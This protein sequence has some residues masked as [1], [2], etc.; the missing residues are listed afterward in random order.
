MAQLFQP[1]TADQAQ[2]T[3]VQALEQGVLDHAVLDDMAEGFGVHAGGGKVDL[4][5]AGA[6]PHLHLGIGA[7]APRD[8][9]VPGADPLEDAL[10]GR[11]QRADPRLERRAGIERLD[12]QRPA[13][14]HQD[15]QATVLQGQ[16]QGG[17]DHAG[18][19]DDHIRT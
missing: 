9:A 1:R 13:I 4:P 11:R 19:D 15:L 2:I 12:R 5:G 16:R 18:T 8:D 7:G 17:T 10:A 3:G 6:V 14:H